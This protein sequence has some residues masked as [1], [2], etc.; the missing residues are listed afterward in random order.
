LRL[1]LF[2]RLIELETTTCPF[3][4]LPEA[5][6]GRWGQGLTAAKMA[7][8]R[9]VGPVLVGQYEFLDWTPDNHLR[10]SRLVA[11]RVDK[12]PRDVY[13]ESDNRRA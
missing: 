5:K 8:C 2:E 10:H 13:A 9:W 4:N 6:S 11:L 1:D 3:S 7:Q 12:N